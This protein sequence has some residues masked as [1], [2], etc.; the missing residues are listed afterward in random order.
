MLQ[1]RVTGSYLMSSDNLPSST[2][3]SGDSAETEPPLYT[4]VFWL[5]YLANALGVMANAL[6]FRFADFISSLGGKEFHSGWI[7][8]T[9]VILAI[10]ARFGLG[11]LLDRWGARPIWLG[12]TIL[13]IISCVLFACEATL[14]WP[15]FVFRVLF[16]VGLAGMFSS[17]I[18]HI[19][20]LAPPHRRTEIIGSLGSSG[21]IGMIAGPLVGDQIFRSLPTGPA[22]Y[23]IMFLSSAVLGL[24]YFCLVW[25]ITL[26][27]RHQSQGESVSAHR[28]IIRYW[29]GP[30]AIVS[31]MMGLGFTVISVFLTRFATYLGLANISTFFIGYAVAAFTF[32]LGTRNWTETLGRHRM[33]LIGLSGI[34]LGQLIFLLVRSEWHL[35]FP[36]LMCG[37]G[38]ALLFPAVVS[39]GSGKF[40]PNYRGTGTTMILGFTELGT[41]VMGPILGAILDAYDG[42]GFPQMFLTTGGIILSVSVYYWLTAA[43]LPDRDPQHCPVPPV[44]PESS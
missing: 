30:I 4:R 12:S 16:S 23:S 11:Q 31:M 35:L 14:S 43:R 20:N 27:E 21:F 28:L 6:T 32:R 22:R 29:P 36:A 26:G 9:G 17:S 38:H 1:C 24:I 5:S 3:L 34:G 25:I 18:V 37:F 2:S 19:Q 10:V 39:L 13:F 42:R 15:L 44:A 7:V 33:V 40:P 8:S 41:V